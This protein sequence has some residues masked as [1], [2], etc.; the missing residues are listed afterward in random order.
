[1]QGSCEERVSKHMLRGL[2]QLP[3]EGKEALRQNLALVPTISQNT[4]AGVGK[5]KKEAG[6]AS[7]TSQG[8][9]LSIRGHL[10]ENSRRLW[11]FPGSAREFWRKV[12]GKSRENCWKK[13]PELRN[14]TNSRISGTVKGKPA[15][16]LGLTLPGPCP[17]LPCR[18][19]FEI[20]SS[21]LPEF[22]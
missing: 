10:S 22:F 8:K 16:N 5:K 17:N 4:K 19:L 20:D 1:M 7:E 9:E 15:G 6:K 11:L 14:A 12:A 3:E 13:F 18:V 21:S 2:V